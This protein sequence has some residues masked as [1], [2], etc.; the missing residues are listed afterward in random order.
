M[1]DIGRLESRISRVE[2]WSTLSL[3]EN[4]TSNLDVIDANG[5]S[6]FQAGF[7]V[8]SFNDHKFSDF[9]NPSN[10]SSLNTTIGEVRAIFVEKNTR[11][12]YK[13]TSGDNDISNN[14]IKK[15]DQLFMQY[16][17]VAETEQLQAS[18]V[19]NVNPYAITT[20]IGF[21]TLSPDSD[22]WRDVETT[23]TTITQTGTLSPTTGTPIISPDQ[24]DHFDNWNTNWT[25]VDNVT[26]STSTTRGGGGFVTGLTFEN[27]MQVR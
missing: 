22:E 13:S 1:R 23:T 7:F 4:E 8:D 18:S 11:M 5:N 2:E 24:N 19:V 27:I 20:G 3:L 6:R 25:G 15:G 10:R 9:S 16:S 26:D 17:E 14:V 21:V 12:I